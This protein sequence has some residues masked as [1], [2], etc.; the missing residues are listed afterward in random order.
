[1]LVQYKNE[2]G[3][4][5]TLEVWVNDT[6]A[7]SIQ[8]PAPAQDEVG[9][10]YGRVQLETG[11]GELD[12]R[13]GED[14]AAADILGGIQAIEI[15]RYEAETASSGLEETVGADLSASGEGVLK[16]TNEADSSA[17]FRSVHVP[18]AGKYRLILGV[19][20]PGDEERSLELEINGSK[21]AKLAVPATGR[22][23]FTE[24]VFEG[25]LQR[26]D[27]EIMIKGAS[28]DLS[29]DYIDIIAD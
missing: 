18:K 14:G 3:A 2:T 10:A 20:N 17:A 23:V 16:L 15:T 21:G 11:G 5:R 13:I 25:K 6:K 12:L 24:V 26:G 28:G 9:Y 22:N 27:N 4:T 19:S 7:G 29:L 1:M 8:L